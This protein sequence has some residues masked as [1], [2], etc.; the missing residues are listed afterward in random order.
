VSPVAVAGARLVAVVSVVLALDQVTKAI[1]V[2]SLA[3]GE[4][5]N[6]FFGIDLTYV[7]NTG[8]AFGAFSG[9]G[10]LVP[11]LVGVAT[12]LLLLFFVHRAATPLIWLPVGAIVGGALGN[13]ADRARDGTVIDFVDPIAWPAFNLADTAVVLGVLGLFYVVERPGSRRPQPRAGA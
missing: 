5:V 6:V 10:A 12:L 3:R 11:I 4:S 8:V 13:L 2:A 7:R 9:G 1:V